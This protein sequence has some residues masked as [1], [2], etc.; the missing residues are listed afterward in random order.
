MPRVRNQLDNHVFAE[1]ERELG[2]PGP[3]AVLRSRINLAIS[4]YFLDRQRITAP[5]AEVSNRLKAVNA[6]ARNLY[7]K[8]N[9]SPVEVA[10]RAAMESA[11][12]RLLKGRKM[13]VSSK[14]FGAMRKKAAKLPNSRY[15]TACLKL[16][17]EQGGASIH[18]F[19]D[20]LNEREVV[21]QIRRLALEQV[22]VDLDL[23]SG[24]LDRLCRFIVS[25]KPS[26]GG[27]PGDTAWGALMSALADAYEEVTGQK[28]T[29]TE[30][31]HRAAE[32]ERYSGQ[33][34]RLATI[35]DRETA[36]VSVPTVSPRSNG[37]I[38]PAL[39][40]LVKAR[41]ARRNKT[42]HS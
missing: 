36:A 13:F 30:N 32:G 15:K 20:V 9:E 17:G 18:E 10:A 21:S 8:L 28:A 7:Q 5:S 39:R 34:T 42:G 6:A 31:E 41:S 12:D 29:V 37:Q 16:F 27:R 2:L 26:K 23:M 19:E 22:G 33:F 14:F 38:G 4:L 25:L 11:F 24:E 3:N 1:I 35:V 40:R